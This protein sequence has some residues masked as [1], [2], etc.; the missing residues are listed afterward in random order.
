MSRFDAPSA[1]FFFFFNDTATTEIYTLS[2]HDALPL[3]FDTFGFSRGA[4]AARHFANEIALGSRGLL[5][6]VLISNAKGFSRHFLGQY[7][8][9]I[10]MGFIGLFDTVASIAGLTNLGNIQSA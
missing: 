4:A 10:Q 9:D 6:R 2:L 5:E 8:R 3:T 7:H 1:F